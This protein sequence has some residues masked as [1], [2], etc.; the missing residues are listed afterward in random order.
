M[1]IYIAMAF[2]AAKYIS[3]AELRSNQMV[4]VDYAFWGPMVLMGILAATFSSALGSIIGAP[5]ILQALSEQRT[6]PLYQ[7]FSKKTRNNE[8]RNAIV[9][10]GGIVAIALPTRKSCDSS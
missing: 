3:P 6:V 8:P 4:M 1:V 2:V 5:R 7:V 10:T 9:F